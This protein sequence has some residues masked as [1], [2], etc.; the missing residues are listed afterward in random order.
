MEDMRDV[1]LESESNIAMIVLWIERIVEWKAVYG[2][3]EEGA[4]V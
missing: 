1:G 3:D 4:R 2:D